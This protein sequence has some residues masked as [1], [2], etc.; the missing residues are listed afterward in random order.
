[1]YWTQLEAW[2]GQQQEA[3]H[4]VAS[5]GGA[6]FMRPFIEDTF[7]KNVSWANRLAKEISSFGIKDKGDIRRLTDCYGLL[8]S[9]KG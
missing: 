7:G 5:G 2:I 3:T 1:L 8:L 9:M 6:I 4:V